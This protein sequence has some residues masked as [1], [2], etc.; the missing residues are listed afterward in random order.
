MDACVVYVIACGGLKKN[1]FA[2]WRRIMVISV[3][4]VALDCGVFIDIMPGDL[5]GE[6]AELG[7]GY[8]I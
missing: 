3:K 8:G 1:L 4:K 5:T 7:C 6:M 2:N